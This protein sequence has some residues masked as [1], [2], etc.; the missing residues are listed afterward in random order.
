MHAELHCDKK[1]GSYYSA[2]FIFPDFFLTL[3]D[4]MNHFP[5]LICSRE[6]PFNRLQSHQKQEW[7]NKF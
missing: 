3:Q 6:I 4:K 2:E 5:W 7:R 1:H